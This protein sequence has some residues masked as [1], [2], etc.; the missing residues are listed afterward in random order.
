VSLRLPQD[1]LPQ[2]RCPARRDRRRCAYEIDHAQAPGSTSRRSA[3]A[4]TRRQQVL[5]P[6]RL[7]CVAPRPT[8]SPSAFIEPRPREWGRGSM[9]PQAFRPAGDNGSVRYL[10]TLQFWATLTCPPGTAMIR[11]RQTPVLSSGLP[12]YKNAWRATPTYVRHVIGRSAATVTV[13]RPARSGGYARL[14][15]FVGA[16]VTLGAVRRPRKSTGAVAEAQRAI[17]SRLAAVNR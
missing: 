8:N 16:P 3:H 15:P 11:K 14:L 4:P 13:A 12:N 6:S 17:R 10:E 7:D 1:V 2:D 5:N 9:A